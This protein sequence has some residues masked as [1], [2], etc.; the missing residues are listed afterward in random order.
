VALAVSLA[1]IAGVAILFISTRGRGPM[2]PTEA[3]SET[4]S[5]IRADLSN[6][7]RDG[8]PPIDA[9]APSATKTATFAMG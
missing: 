3:G 2:V 4:G 5:E 8:I 9:D 7:R 1:G 6:D